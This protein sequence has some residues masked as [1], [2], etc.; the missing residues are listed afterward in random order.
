[1]RLFFG[2]ELNPDDIL[3]ISR[4]RERALPPLDR[5]VPSANLHITLCF[6]GEIEAR[7]TETL[8]QEASLIATRR[9]TLHVDELG[10]FPKPGILWIGPSAPPRELM[11]LSGDARSAAGRAGIRTEQ[12]RYQPHITLA[13]RCQSPPPA[14]VEPPDFELSFS[15][16][17]LFES[18]GGKRGV[19]YEVLTRWSPG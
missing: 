13:R 15:E 19:H 12:R 11:E 9:F 2:L 1:M 17:V 16:F 3:A 7:R 5:P 6:L 18:K 14:G 4:W 8:L 10:Y